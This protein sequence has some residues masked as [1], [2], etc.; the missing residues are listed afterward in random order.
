MHAEKCRREWGAGKR[1]KHGQQSMFGF[2]S[3]AQPAAAAAAAAAAAPAPAPAPEA[4]APEAMDVDNVHADASLPA[5]PSLHAVSMPAPCMGF[6]PDW[7]QPFCAHYP[8]VLHDGAQPLP[9]S[10]TLPEGRFIAGDCLGQQA[11]G[12]EACH[13]CMQLPYNTRFK[14][15]KVREAMLLSARA[16]AHTHIHTHTHTQTRTHTKLHT[17]TRAYTH[18]CT[19]THLH[20]QLHNCTHTHTHAPAH[21]HAHTHRRIA[22]AA[23]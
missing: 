3:K 23:M 7:R 1:A 8:F 19:L 4:A 21:A 15:V 17:R 5:S 2:F 6:K 14:K 12:N 10:V 13:N 18:N 20:T 16:R 9:W 11:A 22:A